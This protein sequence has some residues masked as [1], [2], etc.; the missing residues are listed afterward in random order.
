MNGE[1]VKLKT[2]K[3]NKLLKY[4]WTDEIIN[5]NNQINASA[6][7]VGDK[8]SIQTGDKKWMG[9]ETDEMIFFKYEDIKTTKH[10]R[11]EGKKDP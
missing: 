6:E 5:F 9:N 8:L 3:V 1:N 7:L 11:A 4:T 2:E 10:L